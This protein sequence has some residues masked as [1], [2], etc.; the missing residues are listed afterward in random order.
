MASFN[1][2]VPFLM[3]S[4]ALSSHTFVPCEKPEIRTKSENVWGRESSSMPRTNF[5]PHSGTAKL[6]T[7]SP[8]NCSGVKPIPSVEENKLNV[9]GSSNGIVLASIPVKSSNIRMMVGSSWPRIS[10]L[11]I[12]PS[13]E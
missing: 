10:S 12:R 4:C 2:Q 8:C 13:M 7:W 11:V 3:R 6:A 1:L 5:V 9:F